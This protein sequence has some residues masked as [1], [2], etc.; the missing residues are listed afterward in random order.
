MDINDHIISKSKFLKF[1]YKKLLKNKKFIIVKDFVSKKKILKELKKFKT[2]KPTFKKSSGNLCDFKKSNMSRYD[3]GK[4]RN[5]S[6]SMITHIFYFHN[7]NKLFRNLF[8]E[9][10]KVL[11][12]KNNKSIFFNKKKFFLLPQILEYKL[13]GH[14]SSHVDTN[15]KI[16]PTATI[17]L[18]EFGKDF[19]GGGL[20]Y[21]INNK[22]VNIEKYCDLGS[23]I[24]HKNKTYH[25]VKK[26]KLKKK[27]N[28]KK[29]LILKI[30]ELN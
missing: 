10:I 4:F 27:Q 5:F 11:N 7:K 22:F 30:S 13:N 9:I 26:I 23:L 24:M 3:K 21:E 1:G 12:I 8:N 2:F 29:T 19:S 20:C 25:C 14:L 16:Y 18:S 15:N 28:G 6:R 17:C